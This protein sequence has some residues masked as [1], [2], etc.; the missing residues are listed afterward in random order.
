MLFEECVELGLWKAPKGGCPGRTVGSD[1]GCGFCTSPWFK[2]YLLLTG[3]GTSGT[4][5][6]LSNFRFLLLTANDDHKGISQLSCQIAIKTCME[7]A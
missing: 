6:T 1:S 4:C 7:R 2:F 3:T 5:L